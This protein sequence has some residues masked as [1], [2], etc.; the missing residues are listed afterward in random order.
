MEKKI[1][2]VNSNTAI[3]KAKTI[4]LKDADGNMFLTVELV[5]QP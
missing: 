2:S 1:C 3:S 4:Y 5:Q